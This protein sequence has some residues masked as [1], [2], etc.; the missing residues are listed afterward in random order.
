MHQSNESNFAGCLVQ[1]LGARSCLIEAATGET[2]PGHDI[3]SRIT[4]FAAGLLSQG[5]RPRDRILISCSLTAASALAYLGAMYAGLIPVPVDERLLS[6]SAELLLAKS[7]AKAV[8]S[9]KGIHGSRARGGA[10]EIA[11]LFDVHP[12]GIFPP[13]ACSGDDLAALMPTSG[14]TGVPRL[15]MVSHGNLRA[16]TE[17]IIQSQGLGSD[18]RAMLIMPVS[19][20]FGAS[21]LH[22]HLYQGGGVVFD[23]RFM[24][25][26]KV[27]HAMTRYGCTTF[28][29]VPFVY[30]MLLRRSNLRSIPLP[31]LRRFL[32]AGG[33]L[34]PEK[35]REI[36]EI[37]PTAEFLV[38]YGQT[39]ATARIS[40]FAAKDAPEKLGSAGRPLHNLELR[41]ADEDGRELPN[42]EVGEI[43][44][45]GPSVC[46]GYSDEP[47]PTRRKFRDGWLRTGDF[48]C[49]DDEG[50]LWIKGRAG[51]FVKIRG[52]RVSL[53]EVEARVAAMPG[54]YECAVVGVEHP[55]AGEAVAIF[56]VPENETQVLAQEVRRALPP[57]WTCV[58]VNVVRQLPRTVDGKIE[59]PQLQMAHE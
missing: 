56:V 33:A 54:V 43:Q 37:V 52:L 28:A 46:G 51:E 50:Y 4:D 10:L 24:F 36:C 22:T 19:Y 34:A 40:C 58:S 57:Q 44:V 23:P 12:I 39:E 1:R 8:W 41:I 35:I 3:A 27:L 16:N 30:N 53:G 6:A 59:R 25:P 38:M 29:G 31:G 48:A 42:G 32:Q 14:S 11:G 55:D 26:D 15:V 45:Q 7:Q 20:C 47:E 13:A 17:A 2:L 5:L 49:R 21:V 18:E 9:G